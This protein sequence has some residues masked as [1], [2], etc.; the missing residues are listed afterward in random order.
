MLKSWRSR[1]VEGLTDRT[2]SKFFGNY[3]TYTFTVIV[4]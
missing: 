1:Y 3:R 4:G 2:F